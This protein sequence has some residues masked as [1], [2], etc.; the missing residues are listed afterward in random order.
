MERFEQRVKK[1]TQNKNWTK[2]MVKMIGQF[3]FLPPAFAPLALRPYA[4]KK[5]FNASSIFHS[6]LIFDHLWP[7]CTILDHTEPFK[8]ILSH[9][10]PP[11]SISNHLGPFQTILYHHRPSWTILD[12]SLTILDHFLTFPDHIRPFPAH[13]QAFPFLDISWTYWTIS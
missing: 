10:K 4:F 2:E 6:F 11:C 13:F 3:L 8:T 7:F 1:I 5:K 12:H 9:F